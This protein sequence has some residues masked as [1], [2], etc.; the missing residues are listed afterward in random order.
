MREAL[1]DSR[2]AGFLFAMAEESPFLWTP[3]IFTCT[4]EKI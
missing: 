2:P 4:N 3:F 1:L